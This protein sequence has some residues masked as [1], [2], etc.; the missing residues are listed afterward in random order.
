[1]LLQ[2]RVV[3]N[4]LKFLDTQLSVEIAAK[5]HKKIDEAAHMTFGDDFVGSSAPDSALNHFPDFLLA[6]LLA[7]PGKKL[8]QVPD[9]PTFKLPGGVSLKGLDLLLTD[10]EH[11]SPP[12]VCDEESSAQSLLPQL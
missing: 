8:I 5:R 6:K 3:Q 9:H 2:R 11:V 4:S 7:A 1:M 10:F 12:P